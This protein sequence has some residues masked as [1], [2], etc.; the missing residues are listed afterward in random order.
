MIWLDI[1][2]AIFAFLAALLWFCSALI[3]LPHEFP[4]TVVSSHFEDD[5]A[6][7][8]PVYSTG[9]SQQ[10]DELGKAVIKQSNLSAYAAICAAVAA[11]CQGLRLF[12]G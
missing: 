8:G 1:A 3:K 12:F 7:A 2:S 10:L 4:I 5:I 9:S 11:S 6:P